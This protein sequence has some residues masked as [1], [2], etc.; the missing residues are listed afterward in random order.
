MGN[1]PDEIEKELRERGSKTE[2]E[3]ANRFKVSQVKIEHAVK[4]QKNIVIDP[5]ENE[6]TYKYEMNSARLERKILDGG[7]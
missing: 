4:D 6:R 3:L 5:N 7:L 2:A 1:L